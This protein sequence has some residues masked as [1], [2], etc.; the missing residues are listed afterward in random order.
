MLLLWVNGVR[1]TR[2][3]DWHDRLTPL[4]TYAYERDKLT[5]MRTSLLACRQA[6]GIR[7][8]QVRRFSSP[9]QACLAPLP[10]STA[11]PRRPAQFHCSTAQ[12]CLAPLR[13]RAGLPSS[14]AAPRRPAQL[15]CSTAQACPAPLQ[16]RAGLPSSTAAPRRP[17]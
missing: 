3:G 4:L 6:Y 8:W 11:A 14:T 13:H 10:S 17:A 16:Q 2:Q 15:H 1:W 5:S 7:A 12:A 9:M